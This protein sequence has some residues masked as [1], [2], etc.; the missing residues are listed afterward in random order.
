MIGK[1]GFILLND[2]V[3]AALQFGFI[4]FMSSGSGESI[5]RSTRTDGFIGKARN[6]QY[7]NVPEDCFG[8]GC[9]TS[10]CGESIGDTIFLRG[11]EGTLGE[12][13]LRNKSERVPESELV[14]LADHLFLST[15]GELS[16][17]D[18]GDRAHQRAV[19]D[20]CPSPIAVR[21][22]GERRERRVVTFNPEV[23]IH[24]IPYEDRS[25]QWMRYAID[26]AHFQR[27]VQLFEELFT[28]L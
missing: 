23:T 22:N 12:K 24:L 6:P 26:R 16:E 5:E 27:R 3:L 1:F 17:T 15:S 20:F 25:S 14:S 4:I 10:K 11:S 21:I 2:V 28:A 13:T 18:P 8:S 7:H 19:S 9:G